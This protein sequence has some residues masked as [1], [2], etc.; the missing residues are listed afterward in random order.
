MLATYLPTL[1]TLTLARPGALADVFVDASAG[2]CATANG[3]S[4]QPYCSISDALAAAVA[5][6]RILIRPGVYQE[7]L[8]LPSDLELIGIQGDRV[9]IIDGGGLGTTVTIPSNRTVTLDG[10]TIRGG[11]GV[12]AGGVYSRG[13]LTLRNSTISGN[14]VT[15]S[16]GGAGCTATSSPLAV[17]GCVFEGNTSIGDF[18]AASAIWIGGPTPTPGTTIMNTTISGNTA[19]GPVGG[20]VFVYNADLVMRG[21]TI[22]GNRGP[23]VN[24]F[25]YVA[26]GGLYDATIEGSTIVGNDASGLPFNAIAGGIQQYFTLPVKIRNTVVAGNIGNSAAPDVNGHFISRGGNLIGNW[27]GG[28]GLGGNALDQG[29]T[30]TVPLSAGLGPLGLNGWRTKTHRPM[31]GS[32]VIDRGVDVAGQ[33]FDQR[34]AALPVGSRDVGAVERGVGVTSPLCVPAPNSTGRPTLL[35]ATANLDPTQN[36]MSLTMFDLPRGVFGFCVTSSSV[37]APVQPPMSQGFLCL[38]GA[39]GRLTGPGQVG[40]GGVTGRIQ[41]PLDLSQHPTAA[42]P[43]TVMSGETW[44]FQGW[45]RDQFMGAATS[46]FSA[47]VGV[48]F[49]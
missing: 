43:V 18:Y 28:I 23:G 12:R 3:T 32:P 5:G 7:N 46:N 2:A 26:T 33:A 49:Q 14:E 29:G 16:F 41:V 20:A 8:L 25:G 42:G 34:G 4:A 9:T 19:A 35:V 45:H 36:S 15:A 31:A 11:R 17:D 22:S 48:T 13:A 10:L 1:L 21:S 47:A 24:M 38:T 6:D 27:D 44:Y 39:I 30:T 40:A 37:G